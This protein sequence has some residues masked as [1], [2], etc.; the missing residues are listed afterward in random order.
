[1][2]EISYIEQRR[3]QKLFGKKP[4]QKNV[5]PIARQ[6]D[7]KKKELSNNKDLDKMLDQ[8]FDDRRE[9]MVGICQC[10]CGEKSQKNDDIYYRHC[11]CHILPKAIFPSVATHPLNFV[12]RAF[13]GGC[14]TNMDNRGLDK[15]AN[16]ADWQDIQQKLLILD[17]Y[18]TPQE[19]AHKFFQK[20]QSLF[21]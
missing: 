5:A 15:W 21:K 6:S 19:R 16:M 2:S 3:N 9:Q 10:G 14:H 13:F 12:E 17:E 20:L 11:I 8:W 4:V 1:M 18:L 7:K